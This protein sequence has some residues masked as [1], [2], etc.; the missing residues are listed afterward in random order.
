MQT[1]RLERSMLVP[2]SLQDAF[3]FFED[4]HN[5]ARIT[6]PWLNFRITSPEPIR[7][8]RGAEIAYQIRWLG[9]PL[10]WRTIITEYEPPFFFVDEQAAGPYTLWRHRHDFKPSEKGALVF[11]RVDYALPLGP[12]GRIAHALAVRQQLWKIFDYRQKAL[13][14]ILAGAATEK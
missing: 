12:L 6:P 8:R 9:L 3:Q 1:Y 4:P 11:D 14:E 13:G 10:N 5:L 7:M 2:V